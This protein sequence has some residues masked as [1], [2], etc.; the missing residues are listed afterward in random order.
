MTAESPW[1]IAAGAGFVVAGLIT[2]AVSLVG[3]VRRSLLKRFDISS[4]FY[5]LALAAGTVGVSLGGLMGLGVTTAWYPRIRLVHSHLN[6]VGLVGFTILGTLPTILPT[7]G[8]H[9]AVSGGE[10]LIAWWIAV[11]SG[12]AITIGL[13]RGEAA[14]GLGTV[15]AAAALLMVLTGV[16]GRLGR[17]GREGGLPYFQVTVGSVWLAAWALV[18]GGRLL[19]GSI[20]EPFTAW[21]GAVVIAGLGQILLGSFAYLL[22]VLAGPGSRLGRNLERTNG[23]PWLP[24]ILANVAGVGFVAGFASLASI[25]T[26][27]WVLDFAYRLARIEW[28]DTEAHVANQG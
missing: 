20:A 23:H 21:T 27:L 25:A 28:Q 6:L 4:R 10:V 22:P 17:R 26:G 8:H 18:D 7:F 15:L 14:V 12:A 5:L 13:A 11:A 16:V 19:A 2:L 9:K 24:L 3:A 1:A